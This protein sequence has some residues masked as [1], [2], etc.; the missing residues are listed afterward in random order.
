M[1][2]SDRTIDKRRG[3][4]HLRLLICSLELNLCLNVHFQGVYSFV[5]LSNM[6]TLTFV[7]VSVYII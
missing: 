6:S 3:L 1:R 5:Y 7:V 2:F 4:D